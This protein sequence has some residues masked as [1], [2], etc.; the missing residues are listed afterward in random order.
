M[1]VTSKKDKNY[2]ICDS[3]IETYYY[4]IGKHIKD[5]Y[6]PYKMHIIDTELFEGEHHPLCK[7]PHIPDIN[8][9][10]SLIRDD[11]SII[12]NAKTFRGIE[13]INCAIIN[14]LNLSG[15]NVHIKVKIKNTLP[16]LKLHSR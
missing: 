12:F 11:S 6:T 2:K 10:E 16:F 1:V 9:T 8:I 4:S 5:K 15:L 7:I 3:D 13:N 14:G